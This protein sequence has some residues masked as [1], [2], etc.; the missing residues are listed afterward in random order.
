[1]LPLPVGFVGSWKLL[2]LKMKKI[3]MLF[4]LAFCMNAYAQLDKKEVRQIE[5]TACL[6][7]SDTILIS[8]HWINKGATIDSLFG[9]TGPADSNAWGAYYVNIKDAWQ[10][11]A[12]ISNLTGFKETPAPIV[13]IKIENIRMSAFEVSNKNYRDY[14]DWTRIH[15]PEK[16]MEVLPDTQL[17]LSLSRSNGPMMKY[18][19]MH[20]AY[21]DHPVTNISHRQAHAYLQWLTDQYNQSPKR[22]YKKVVF[23]LPTEAEWMYAWLGGQSILTVSNMGTFRNKK[24]QIMANYRTVHDA[25]IIR[26]QNDEHVTF[27][28]STLDFSFTTYHQQIGPDTISYELQHKPRI[29]LGNTGFGYSEGTGS[30]YTTPVASYWP[31]PYGIFNMSGNVAEFVQT[32]DIAKGGH[33]YTTGFYLLGTSRETF[34]GQNSASPTRGFRWVMEVIE[35]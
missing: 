16:I 6:L 19:F 14:V 10:A 15:H 17:W 23:R 12:Y 29:F 28:D 35:E 30:M 24:G 20:P 2:N 8:K 33:F 31:N 1:M 32:E 11:P 4:S 7:P 18:Y 34:I 22:K 26:L 21:N 13:Q 27:S 25:E 5:K 9:N 3:L